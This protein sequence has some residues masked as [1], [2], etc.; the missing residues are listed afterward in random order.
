MMYKTRN[1]NGSERVVYNI[2]KVTLKASLKTNKDDKKVYARIKWLYKLLYT[3]REERKV[4]S[5]LY[6][7]MQMMFEVNHLDEKYH[8]TQ[9]L[10]PGEVAL[11]EFDEEYEA[12]GVRGKM[13][14]AYMSDILRK[15]IKN[16]NM[17]WESKN[18]NPAVILKCFN[19]YWQIGIK[20][21]TKRHDYLEFNLSEKEWS[22]FMV[23]DLDLT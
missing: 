1:I 12:R 7:D 8:P 13:K 20:I 22:E 17:I 21:T 6:D 2:N 16:L 4:N 14:S 5:Q 19:D 18:L 23:R 15:I 3:Y 9:K 11:K 10:G